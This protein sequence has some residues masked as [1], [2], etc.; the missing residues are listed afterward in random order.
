MSEEISDQNT[1]WTKNEREIIIQGLIQ[2]TKLELDRKGYFYHADDV[3]YFFKQDFISEEILEM[4]TKL[5][6]K[7][8]RSLSRTNSL[9]K[10]FVQKYMALG[11]YQGHSVGTISSE[12]LLRATQS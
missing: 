2:L 9:F 4:N 8:G 5:V 10:L 7:F 6:A 12:M 11:E 3:E 1:I